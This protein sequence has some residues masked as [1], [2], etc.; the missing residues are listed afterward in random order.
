MGETKFQPWEFPRSGPKA[1]EVEERKKEK[2]QNNGQ[3]RFCLSPQVEHASH[4]DQ[5]HIQIL[6]HNIYL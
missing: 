2:W 3:L 1:E 5:F 6:D 4:L